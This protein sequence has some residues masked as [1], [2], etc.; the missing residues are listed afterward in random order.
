MQAQ[1]T[2]AASTFFTKTLERS[3]EQ[4]RRLAFQLHP[5]SSRLIPVPGGLIGLALTL[6]HQFKPVDQI[7]QQK[8]R[9]ANGKL[10][11]GGAEG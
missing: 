2:N 6:A 11:G 3:T 4:L 7:V 1:S 8:Q 9:T 10:G 5:Y